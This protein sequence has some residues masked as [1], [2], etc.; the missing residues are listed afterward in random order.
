[1]RSRLGSRCVRPGQERCGRQ[2]KELR[3]TVRT[4]GQLG[5]ASA[6]NLGSASAGEWFS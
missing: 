4:I 1:M 2:P 3:F 5:R 6:L